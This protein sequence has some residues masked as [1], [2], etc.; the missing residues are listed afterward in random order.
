MRNPGGCRSRSRYVKGREDSF[1]K[2]VDG[3]ERKGVVM[4]AGGQVMEPGCLDGRSADTSGTDTSA[5]EVT[6]PHLTSHV[7]EAV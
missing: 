6:R 4:M 1:D 2:G 3:M 7:H 5:C